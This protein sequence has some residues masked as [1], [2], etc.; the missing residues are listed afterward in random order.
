MIFSL[1]V[2]ASDCHA[3]VAT[4]LGSIPASSDT[5][6]SKGRQLKQ[7][8]IQ[9]KEKKPKKSP[10]LILNNNAAEH[11]P[12]LSA[13]QTQ[14]RWCLAVLGWRL[15][16]D[17]GTLLDLARVSAC[18]WHSFSFFCCR[19]HHAGLVCLVSLKGQFH[20]KKEHYLF[21]SPNKLNQS[22][23]CLFS[24]SALWLS[25]FLNILLVR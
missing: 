21:R 18:M 23:T 19:V 17:R 22:P 6:E 1:V 15:S 13:S 4:V 11:H 25:V 12:H 7:S 20:E 8:W 3:E 2:R 9:Y 24:E 16:R 5:V 14:M 10:V